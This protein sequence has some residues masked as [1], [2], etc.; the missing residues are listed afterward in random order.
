MVDAN[1][2]PQTEVLES[3]QRLSKDLVLASTKLGDHEVRF[4]VD[5]FYIMQ[6]DRKRANSQELAFGEEEPHEIVTWLKNQS[7]TLE[8]QILRALEKYTD[9]HVLGTWMKS[10]YGV[11]PVISAGILSH[12]DIKL[13]PTAGT[14]WRRAGLDPTVKWPSRDD[15]MK[16]VQ[17]TTKEMPKLRGS[18]L[19]IYASEHWGRSY[20]VLHRILDHKTKFTN[21]ELA[22]AL[23]RMP[24][25]PK[26]KVLCFK[27][28]QCFMKFHNH[29][30]C[31]YGH[32]YRERKDQ[33]IMRNERGDYRENALA[34]ASRFG[35]D[36]EAYKSYSVGKYP[37]AHIDARA[38]RYAVKLFLAHFHEEGYRRIMHREPPKPYPIA[39]L[40]HT[41]YIPPA[42][43]A[44]I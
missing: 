14:I 28:G 9:D 29:P 41:H 21:E 33:E 25:N 39:V 18:A 30:D 40:G 43:I 4:L 5:A 6:D 38:R 20:K 31:Y 2:S 44:T 23:S 34:L 24:W 27:I 16:W 1:D 13:S 42:S 22:K 7:H 8:K 17:A 35:R 37:P 26:L 11:G 10:N 32:I 36:T 3:V 19:V 15:A 12:I